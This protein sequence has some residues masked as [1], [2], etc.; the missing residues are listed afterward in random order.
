M[1]I[2]KSI[3]VLIMIGKKINNTRAHTHI[4]HNMMQHLLAYEQFIILNLE[5]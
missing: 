4:W 2:G 5:L 3:F 1:E